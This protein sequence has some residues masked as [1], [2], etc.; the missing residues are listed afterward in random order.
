[1]TVKDGDLIVAKFIEIKKREQR[2]RI[3]NILDLREGFALPELD[4]LDCQGY[5]Q[6]R[7]N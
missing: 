7:K 2:E 4:L 1:M 3:I 5:Y 6:I